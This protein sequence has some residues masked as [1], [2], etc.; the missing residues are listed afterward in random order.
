MTCSR[1][2]LGGE[3][4]IDPRAGGK[5]RGLNGSEQGRVRRCEQK[6]ELCVSGHPEVSPARCIDMD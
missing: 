3:N 4:N 5:E 6:G 1:S 2:S